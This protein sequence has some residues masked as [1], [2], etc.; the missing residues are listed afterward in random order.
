VY[1]L[2]L[3]LNLKAYKKAVSVLNKHIVIGQIW[4]FVWKFRVTIGNFFNPTAFSGL[5]KACLRQAYPSPRSH[6][7]IK[8]LLKALLHVNHQSGDCKF[9]GLLGDCKFQDSPWNPKRLRKE[10]SQGK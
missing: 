10:I 7:P 3:I 1:S 5:I 9:Q 8:F 4:D 6:L 2:D